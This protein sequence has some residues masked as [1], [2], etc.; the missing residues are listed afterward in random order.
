MAKLKRS[1]IAGN[2]GSGKRG[3][4]VSTLICAVLDDRQPEM[5]DE[6]PKFVHRVSC[7]LALSTAV[8]DIPLSF[9]LAVVFLMQTMCGSEISHGRVGIRKTRQNFCVHQNVVKMTKATST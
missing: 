7:V 3:G 4:G 2:Y 8:A 1:D 5:D 6:E 9:A